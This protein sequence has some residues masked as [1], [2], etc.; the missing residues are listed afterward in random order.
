MTTALKDDQFTSQSLTEIVWIL[1][2]HQMIP[3]TGHHQASNPTRLDLF[4]SSI[5]HR[6]S[7]DGH[8]LSQVTDQGLR[9]TA[10]HPG[11]ILSQGH[12]RIG[13]V[14]FMFDRRRFGREPLRRVD[15]GK[16]LGE[17]VGRIPGKDQSRK[18]RDGLDL[19][20]K[21][22]WVWEVFESKESYWPV[23]SDLQVWCSSTRP[24]KTFRAISRPIRVRSCL[25][26]RYRWGEHVFAIQ[27]GPRGQSR[28]EPFVKCFEVISAWSD[29]KWSYL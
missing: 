10:I 23:V 13:L 21:K 4:Q 15:E 6:V 5:R 14:R 11:Q 26:W 20:Q 3:G 7:Q 1:W 16:G 27:N 22:K 19:T 2:V 8:H 24:K 9:S 17:L 18:G 25:P 29:W 12:V 28:H